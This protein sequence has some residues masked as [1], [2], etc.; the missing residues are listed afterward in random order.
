MTGRRGPGETT[1]VTCGTQPRPAGDG[2]AG[3]TGRVAGW[4]GSR[5]LVLAGAGAVVVEAGMAVVSWP[6]A[7]VVPAIAVV[8]A[9]AVAPAVMGEY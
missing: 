7:C 6:A 3:R 4:L 8:A 1:C 9:M 2:R 5:S